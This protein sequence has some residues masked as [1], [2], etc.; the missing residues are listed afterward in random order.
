MGDECRY[1]LP[2]LAG[3]IRQY[4]LS[5]SH[6][7]VWNANTSIAKMSCSSDSSGSDFPM[8]P[9][10]STRKRRGK[11]Y[12]KDTASS[13]LCSL[14]KRSRYKTRVTRSCSV[15]RLRQEARS[16]LTT[17]IFIFVLF[18][19]LYGADCSQDCYTDEGSENAKT[20]GYTFGA[21]D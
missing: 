6:E 19:K 12:A 4:G 18:G 17:Q 16:Q 8:P 5:Y 15:S 10:S 1:L 7:L 2:V 11:Q 20:V 9:F 3:M 14:R 13:G 21:G